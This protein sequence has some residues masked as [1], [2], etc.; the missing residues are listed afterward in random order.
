MLSGAGHCSPVEFPVKEMALPVML[1]VVMTLSVVFG[2]VH[3]AVRGPRGY[4]PDYSQLSAV[5]LIPMVRQ[6][7]LARVQA[8]RRNLESEDGTPGIFYGRMSRY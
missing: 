3:C 1:Q 8:I 4:S 5:T 7:Q 6:S 2:R